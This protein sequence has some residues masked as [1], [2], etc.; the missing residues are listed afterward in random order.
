MKKFSYIIT[1]IAVLFIIFNLTK[2]DFV[3]PFQGE[4]LIAVITIIAGLCVILLMAILRVSKKIDNIH[5]GK[6]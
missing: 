1:A 5:K 2:I 6:S 3:T 4:S